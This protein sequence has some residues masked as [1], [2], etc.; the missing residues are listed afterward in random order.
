MDFKDIKILILED[1][2][3]IAENLRRIL[4]NLG[5]QKVY[6]ATNVEKASQLVASNQLDL[7][8]IDINLGENRKTGTDFILELINHKPIPHI[9]ITANVDEKNI[10]A[11]SATFPEGFLEKPY[12]QQSIQAAITIALR[13]MDKYKIAVN[14]NNK[15]ILIDLND[16]LFVESEK[17]YVNIYLN[18]GQK[19]VERISLRQ[20]LESLTS[21]FVQ[22]HKSFAV[23]IDKVDVYSGSQITIKEHALPI[24]RNYK[25]QFKEKIDSLLR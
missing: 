15:K 22:I 24:G 5:T 10:K 14:L 19:C 4:L 23:N 3:L 9:Y 11:A 18:N 16:I 2:E 17:N 25:S 12:T 13:K 8:L 1:Q 21:N 20:L 6:V 7:L